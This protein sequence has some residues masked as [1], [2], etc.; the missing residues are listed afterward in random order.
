MTLIL[1]LLACRPEVVETP[2]EATLEVTASEVPVAYNDVL[3]VVVDARGPSAPP[4]LTLT[5][6]GPEGQALEPQA[7]PLEGWSLFTAADRHEGTSDVFAG[8]FHG[9]LPVPDGVTPGLWSLALEDSL[10]GELYRLDGLAVGDWGFVEDEDPAALLPL[11]QPLL[12]RM[13]FSQPAGLGELLV[14]F[15]GVAPVLELASLEGDQLSWRLHLT[16]PDWGEDGGVTACRLLEGVATLAPDGRFEGYDAEVVN[17]M[18]GGEQ[19]SLYDQRL[20][21]AVNASG[22]LGA[23]QLSG[24]VDMSL[25]QDWSEGQACDLL[26]GFGVD[27]VPCEADPEQLCLDAALALRGPAPFDALPAYEDMPWCS[28]AEEDIPSLDFDFDVDFDCSGCAAGGRG[29]LG[30]AGLGLLLAGLVRRREP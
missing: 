12:A 3:L 5:W 16:N 18:S 10:A 15:T 17:T 21:G 28:A 25:F 23:L 14:D 11:G 9:Q 24:S 1:T 29:G 13:D 20:S 7:I 2:L 6:E 26:P 8:R 27:C 22:D 19:F 30:W 4:E